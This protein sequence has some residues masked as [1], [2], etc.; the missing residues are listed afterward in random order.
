MNDI[1]IGTEVL[2]TLKNGSEIVAVDARPL[3]EIQAALYRVKAGRL[4]SPDL[5]PE[6]A[7]AVNAGRLPP[8]RPQSL[9]ELAARAGFLQLAT[10]AVKAS[11]VVAIGLDDDQGD[12]DRDDDDGSA[13][14]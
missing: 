11:E 12:D 1:D 9:E 10:V 3:P 14:T 2:I 4:P 6:E 5:S 7:A 13:W 8:A